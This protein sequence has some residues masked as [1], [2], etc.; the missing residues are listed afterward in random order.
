MLVKTIQY[1]KSTFNTPWMISFSKHEQQYLMSFHKHKKQISGFILV[2]KVIK[3]LKKPILCN[4]LYFKT[5]IQLTNQLQD[6]IATIKHLQLVGQYSTGDRLSCL[7]SQS[8]EIILPASLNMHTV[9]C[10]FLSLYVK[11][12]GFE[13]TKITITAILKHLKKHKSG[14]QRHWSCRPSGNYEAIR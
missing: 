7:N 6:C 5:H 9:V 11:H 14:S 1:T 4:L 3:Q 8:N 12:L 13:Y 2:S 10:I